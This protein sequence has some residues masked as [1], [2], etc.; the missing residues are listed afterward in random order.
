ML[1]SSIVQVE[2]PA[3]SYL[4]APVLPHYCQQDA[5]HELDSA[6]LGRRV[7][8]EWVT[9]VVEAIRS[10]A[11]SGHTEENEWQKVVHKE[12]ARQRS[13]KGKGQ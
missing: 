12:V 9:S 5:Q 11:G 13:T 8:L 3:Q 10:P 1:A 6:L 4:R 7:K 2:S